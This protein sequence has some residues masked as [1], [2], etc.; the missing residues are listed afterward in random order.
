MIG[1]EL[2][3][4]RDAKHNA[5]GSSGPLKARTAGALAGAGGRLP[6]DRGSKVAFEC[7]KWGRVVGAGGVRQCPL[8]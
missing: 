6:A 7:G 4:L 5:E 1:A 8:A 2:R 3:R